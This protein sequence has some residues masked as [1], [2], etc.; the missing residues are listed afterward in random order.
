MRRRRWD[1]G[2]G[3]EIWPVFWGM[4]FLEAAFGAYMGVW[5]LWIER[6]GAP[7]TVVGLVLGSS[8]VLRL[9]ALAPAAHMGERF[10][11]RRLILA[12]RTVA[13]LGLLS[14]ALATHWTH[15]FVMVVGSAVGELAF[16][17]VQ[18]HVARHAGEH[19]VRAFALVFT[20]GPSVALGLGPLAAG[21]LIAGWGLRAAF[22]FAALCTAASIACFA[23]LRGAVPPPAGEAPDRDRASY[24][25]AVGDA[26]VRRLLVLQGATIFALSLGTSLVPT[27]LADVRGMGDAR[28]AL[29]GAGA[30]VGSTLF[31]LAVSRMAKLQR[32]P[33]VGVAA[34]VACTLVGF[35]LFLGSAAPAL[36]ALAFV[37]RGGF[38]AAWSLFAATLGETAAEPNRA[39]AFALSEM[40]GGFM[41]SVAPMVAGLLYAARPSLPLLAATVLCA[42]L[43][44]VLV[45]AQRHAHRRARPVPV[46]QPEAA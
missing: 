24:R 46:A 8:G 19:R 15:L 37:C 23:R 38:F 22:L 30:A 13:G 34:A 2:L 4:S 32:S 27:F 36:V 43:V 5:P 29:Y 11:A 3:R 14:A 40:I 12:A 20:V 17:L 35:A 16:P 18:A 10:G 28:I 33:Y 41:Y 9:L 45:Q 31:G 39:R 21:L 7:V 1:P 25:D 42:A 6:L 26:A 44:P